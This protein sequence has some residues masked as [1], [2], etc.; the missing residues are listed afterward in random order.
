MPDQEGEVSN[1]GEGVKQDEIDM[2][3]EGT[4]VT[5]AAKTAQEKKLPVKVQPGI[6]YTVKIKID[7]F[8][9]P[10]KCFNFLFGKN[11]KTN[12]S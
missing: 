4:R 5:Q 8:V 6:F 3:W 2:D 12:C 10:N 1:D 7:D 9:M 11:L